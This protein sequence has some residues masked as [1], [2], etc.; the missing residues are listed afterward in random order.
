MNIPLWD[1]VS[2]VSSQYIQYLLQQSTGDAYHPQF[3]LPEKQN[4]ETGQIQPNFHHFTT[5]NGLSVKANIK[6]SNAY[7]NCIYI[8]VSGT[9]CGN[10]QL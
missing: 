6:I 7:K 2:L 9:W 4:I 5:L 10:I 3:L 1:R 8:Y